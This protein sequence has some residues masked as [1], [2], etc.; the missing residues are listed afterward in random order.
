MIDYNNTILI[1]DQPTSCPI[2][3]VRTDFYTTIS[4]TSKES[5]E[6]HTCISNTCQYEFVAEEDEDFIRYIEEEQVVGS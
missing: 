2:C 1:N 6:I 3:G 4:P 5:V